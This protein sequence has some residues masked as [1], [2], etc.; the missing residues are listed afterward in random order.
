MESRITKKSKRV[1]MAI[2]LPA[3]SHHRCDQYCFGP[4]L[5]PETQLKEIQKTLDLKH[6]EAA[7]CPFSPQPCRRESWKW[8]R[9]DSLRRK[10][11]SRMNSPMTRQPPGRPCATQEGHGS[12]TQVATLIVSRTLS[13]PPDKQAKLISDN[14]RTW[15]GRV[16]LRVNPN[17]LIQQVSQEVLSKVK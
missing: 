2:P 14:H 15:M 3:Q 5:R 16:Q 1:R 8:L 6:S 7:A 4:M 12:D 10:P 13:I 17:N 9:N 11:H